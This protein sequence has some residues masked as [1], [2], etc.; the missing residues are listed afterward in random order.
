MYPAGGI[1]QSLADASS[2]INVREC[3]DDRHVCEEIYEC[4][5]N[6]KTMDNNVTTKKSAVSK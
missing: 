1:G 5:V 3:V 4:I 2:E 6:C